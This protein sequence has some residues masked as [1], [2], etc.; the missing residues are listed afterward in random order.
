[1]ANQFNKANN[2]YGV[3]GILL[4][5]FLMINWIEN[6]TINLHRITHKSSIQVEVYEMTVRI[7]SIVA[8]HDGLVVVGSHQFNVQETRSEIEQKIRDAG[9]Y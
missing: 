9:G 2:F 3:V 4:R 6:M 7:D 1:M 5:L 8:Y